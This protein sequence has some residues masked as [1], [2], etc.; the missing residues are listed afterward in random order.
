MVRGIEMKTI[1]LNSA[2]IPHGFTGICEYVTITE[3]QFVDEINKCKD[4]ESYL[5]YEE[6]ISHVLEITGRKFDFNRSTFNIQ[7]E[8]VRALVVRVTYRV[9][10]EVKGKDLKVAT[11]DYGRIIFRGGLYGDIY[12]DDPYKYEVDKIIYFIRKRFNDR[13]NLYRISISQKYV[14]N[15]LRHQIRGALNW[16]EENINICDQESLGI[17]Y[18]SAIALLNAIEGPDDKI[19]VELL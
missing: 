15:L 3:E 1:L 6:T 12:I 2:V 8:P 14:K 16:M 19:D 10:P 17:L 13:L 11:W 9:E 7:D 5:G 4:I 18:C